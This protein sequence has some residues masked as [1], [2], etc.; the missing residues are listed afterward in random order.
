MFFRFGSRLLVRVLF[1]AAGFSVPLALAQEAKPAAPPEKAASAADEKSVSDRVRRSALSPLRVILE[2][3]RLKRA[4]A[5]AEP[6]T[7]PAPA[8]PPKRAAAPAK[9]AANVA[10]A[11]AVAS[12]PAPAE[13]VRAV[14]QDNSAS[15]PSAAAIDSAVL[16]AAPAASA[17]IPPTAIPPAATTPSATAAPPAAMPPASQ[18]GPLATP[19]RNEAAAQ[20]AAVA[21]SPLVLHKVAPEIPAAARRRVGPFDELPVQVSVRA[22]GS[23]ADAAVLAVGMRLIES[24]VVEALKQWRYAPTG[25][26]FTHRFQLVINNE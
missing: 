13:Q 11:P 25:Q 19:V 6:S 16:P 15:A 18:A 20:A 10:A 5:N 3:A 7:A 17:A 24:Y 9:A 2:A 23:V 12:T 22:D 26:P 1:A 8:A 21:T 4:S 14:A